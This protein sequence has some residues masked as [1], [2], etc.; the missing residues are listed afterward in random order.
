MD[1]AAP[2]VTPTMNNNKEDAKFIKEYK[3]NSDNINYI[4]KIGK[5][6]NENEEM[7][8]FVEDKNKINSCYYQNSFSLKNLQIMYKI[9]R[10]FDTIDE[11][12]N[13][14]KDIISD[15]QIT[16]LKEEDNLSIIFKFQ[17]LRKQI[18]EINFILRKNNKET[19]KIIDN[20]ISNI[21]NINQELQQLKKEINSKKI[22]IYHPVLQNGWMVDP[23]TPQEFKVCKNSDGQVSFQGAVSGDW[24]KKIFTL[25]KE[26]RSKYR[27][28]FPIIAN[29]AFN[30][31]DILP[32]GDVYLSFH[33]SLGV[34]GSGWANLSGI[35]YY[36]TE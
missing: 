21:N 26:F 16:I 23:N 35:T 30:R 3:F 11:A 18:E 5:V 1:M 29:Q 28:T 25:E 20:L 2:L 34:T 19:G 12:I 8:I 6:V 24:S 7:I 33:A 17:N 9:F 27:L 13:V 4:L 36:I 31:C 14:L 32:N 10:Q 22:K 15:K